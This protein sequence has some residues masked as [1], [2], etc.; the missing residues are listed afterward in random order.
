MDTGSIGLPGLRLHAKR[1]YPLNELSTDLK[2]DIVRAYREVFEDNNSMKAELTGYYQSGWLVKSTPVVR[3]NSRAAWREDDRSGFGVTWGS[4]GDLHVKTD[5]QDDLSRVLTQEYHRRGFAKEEQK[6]RERIAKGEIDHFHPSVQ[7]LVKRQQEFFK[8]NFPEVFKAL[9]I[10]N[11]ISRMDSATRLRG[12]QVLDASG[13]RAIA[14]E[15]MNSF[16]ME[17]ACGPTTFRLKQYAI[18]YQKAG[19][20]KREDDIRASL[21]SGKLTMQSEEVQ[22]LIEDQNTFLLR[23]VPNFYE[24][25]QRKEGRDR[26][27][28]LTKGM[29]RFGQEQQQSYIMSSLC[30]EAHGGAQKELAEFVE[31]T[32]DKEFQEMVL[33]GLEG[34]DKEKLRRH[35]ANEKLLDAEAYADLVEKSTETLLDQLGGGTAPGEDALAVAAPTMTENEAI[36]AQTLKLKDQLIPHITDN[37]RRILEEYWGSKGEKRVEEAFDIIGESARKDARNPSEK[38]PVVLTRWK[39]HISRNNAFISA[40]LRSGFIYIGFRECNEEKS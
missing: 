24:L 22:Q 6:L 30:V 25:I 20:K 5:I 7:A 13:N 21:A 35:F 34:E 10:E 26:M 38:P 28:M 31:Q 17:R 15:I 36:A 12:S 11:G 37:E 14:S 18:E 29:D 16:L 8:R 27:E 3:E 4:D 19:L 1:W 32:K 39:C 33:S 23:R 2:R 9:G 40:I